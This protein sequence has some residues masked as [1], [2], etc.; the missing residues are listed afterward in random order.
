MSIF[1]YDNQP[2]AVEL[3]FLFQL[4]PTDP[5]N[6]VHYN[7]VPYM[8]S[9][10]LGRQWKVHSMLSPGARNQENGNTYTQIFSTEVNS[11]SILKEPVIRHAT[12]NPL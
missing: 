2:L 6:R 9:I 5:E 12:G 7:I 1:P 3:P 4:P 10:H 8:A 11:S